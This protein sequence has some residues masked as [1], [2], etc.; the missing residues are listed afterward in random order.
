ML[1]TQMLPKR[2]VSY[3]KMAKCPDERSHFHPLTLQ[4]RK[5][6]LVK[7]LCMAETCERQNWV[8]GLGPKNG[9]VNLTHAHQPFPKGGQRSWRVGRQ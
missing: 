9:L 2:F 3:G 8:P 6:R 5:Q 7:M 1:H 4:M